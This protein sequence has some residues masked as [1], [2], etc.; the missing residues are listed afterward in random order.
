MSLRKWWKIECER[1][2]DGEPCGA[3][4]QVFDVPRKQALKLFRRAGW[5]IG[6]AD[7]WDRCPSCKRGL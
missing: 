3:T 5:L 1:K 6:A 4:A 2:I 7:E